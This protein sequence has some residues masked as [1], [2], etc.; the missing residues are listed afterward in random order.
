M[1]APTLVCPLL[2][3]ATTV[4]ACSEHD[5]PVRSMGGAGSSVGAGANA[6]GA[7]AGETTGGN[8]RGGSENGMAGASGSGA[9]GTTTAPREPF[10]VVISGA[11]VDIYV[12]TADYPGVRRVVE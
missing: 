11:A 9:G 2:I 6:A 12:D 1:R 8:G 4:V 5:G 7:G 10:D 3:V